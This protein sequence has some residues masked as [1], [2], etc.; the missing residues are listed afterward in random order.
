MT[1]NQ[2]L[3]DK[4]YDKIEKEFKEFTKSLQLLQPNEIIEKAYE[5]AIKQELTYVIQSDLFSDKEIKNL[6]AVDELL[7]ECYCEWLK[8]EDSIIDSLYDTVMDFYRKKGAKNER[9]ENTLKYI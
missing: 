5:I 1:K 2:N 9:I 7:S 4:L 3:K 8:N 6:L